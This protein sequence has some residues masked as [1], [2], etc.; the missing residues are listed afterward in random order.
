MDATVSSVKGSFE[1][2]I[3]RSLDV[4]IDANKPFS[5]KDV[6][7]GA[8]FRDGSRVGKTTLY[9]KD[10]QTSE[11]VYASLLRDI[12]NAVDDAKS[13][14]TKKKNASGK[15]MS[16]EQLRLE[17]NSL[18]DENSRLTDAVVEQESQLK[19][20]KS[21]ESIDNNLVKK[22]ELQVYLANAI[23]LRTVHQ[24]SRAYSQAKKI[25]ERLEVKYRGTAE[26]KSVEKELN[27]LLQN[28]SH[29][30]LYHFQG[31]F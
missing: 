28:I 25:V 4:L 2:A 13:S 16:P 29:S 11:Y 10:Q 26:I 6:I 23:L 3:K 8:K 18:K 31:K 20:L 22:L 12:K 27:S 5:Q 15:A 9:K 30:S 17:N 24:S 7:N 14:P 19:R 1:E 21:V